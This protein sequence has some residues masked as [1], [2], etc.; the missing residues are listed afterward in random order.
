MFLQLF[1]GSL[2]ICGCGSGIFLV[3]G[4]SIASEARMEEQSL[5]II[6][7]SHAV[8]IALNDG[9]ITIMEGVG[10][11]ESSKMAAMNFAKKIKMHYN[12]FEQFTSEPIIDHCYLTGT[13][14]CPVIEAD[15][16][17]KV[18]RV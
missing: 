9:T 2:I 18:H 3:Y 15:H 11:N 4:S 6:Y 13:K 10:S 5:P 14:D 7:R 1:Q 8:Y 16:W 12:S 17:I